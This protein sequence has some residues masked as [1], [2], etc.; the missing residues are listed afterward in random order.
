M[1][2]HS[3]G[4]VE[5]TQQLLR[6]GLGNMTFGEKPRKPNHGESPPEH[7]LVGQ[8]LTQPP[9]AQGSPL[10]VPGTRAHDHSVAEVL[11]NDNS[12]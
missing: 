8:V 3:G 4:H 9:S 6:R 2:L 11:G 5:G 10:T 12:W 1:P 7:G